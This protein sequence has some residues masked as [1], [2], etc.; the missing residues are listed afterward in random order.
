MQD[1]RLTATLQLPFWWYPTRYAHVQSRS[2]QGI[3]GH[4]VR[5]CM[6]PGLSALS[7]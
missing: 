5:V 2:N 6:E 4:G 3:L 7:V 1:F